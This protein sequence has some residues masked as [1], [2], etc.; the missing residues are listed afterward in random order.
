MN[1]KIQWYKEILEVEPQ[2]RMFFPLARM[3]VDAG[4]LSEA[5]DVLTKG[6]LYHPD[7]MQARM[8]HV[9]L[10]HRLGR[11]EEAS[12]ELTTLR[13]A[14]S[15]QYNVWQDLARLNEKDDARLAVRCMNLLLHGIPINFA[16]LLL[17]G[18]ESL[19]AEHGLQE[20]VTSA[21]QEIERACAGLDE[22]VDNT[23]EST[24]H[25]QAG[26]ASA[27]TA[28]VGDVLTSVDEDKLYSSVKR[29]LNEAADS[30]QTDPEGDQL[31]CM[32]TVPETD[33]AWEPDDGPSDKPQSWPPHTRSMADVLVDQGEYGEAMDIYHELLDHA[34]SEEEIK[35]LDE[36]L[37]YIKELARGAFAHQSDSLDDERQANFDDKTFIT[38]MNAD[39]GINDEQF[40]SMLS[41]L[42]ARVEARAQ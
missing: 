39:N 2:S 33:T 38:N 29:I 26:A 35:E 15:G 41:T 10:L 23:A 13:T 25:A 6:L 37:D 27:A 9:D 22:A 21:R 30:I 24:V 28:V 31:Q 36:R 16:D 32:Q 5:C 40:L 14:L 7:H 12:S 20:R 42:A 1:E 8:L 18:I 3:L 11:Q 34:G 4:C 19:E 17:R